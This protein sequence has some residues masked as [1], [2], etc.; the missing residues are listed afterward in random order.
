MRVRSIDELEYII[1]KDF[2]WRRKELTVF[3]TLS[4]SSKKQM[5]IILL[6]SGIALLYSHW[7]G[8]IKN[9]SIAYCEYI[10]HKNI[11]Y[12]NL[13][14]NFHVCAI[15]EEFQG[16]YPH[17]NFKSAFKLVEDRELFFER[18][19][20]INSE[21]YIDTGSNLNSEILKEITMKIGVDYSFYELK[22][23][24]INERFLGFRNAISH[25]EY[26]EIEENDFVYLFEEITA[27]IAIFKN[28]IINS[29][30][31]ESYLEGSREIA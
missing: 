31:Q 13:I 28:Q 19:C 8:F 7:E 15:L 30:I 9:A 11:L 25:G 6:K 3:K 22:G 26:R 17:R 5:K 21:K 14:H 20:K 29:A 16:Q 18:K 4:L 12:K 23:N 10:N 1:A 24:L 2:S 27:L